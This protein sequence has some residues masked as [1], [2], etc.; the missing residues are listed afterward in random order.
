LWPGFGDNIR[1]LDWITRRVDGERGGSRTT[2]IGDVPTFGGVDLSGLDIGR[3]SFD[4]LVAVDPA[5]WLEESERN[6]GFLEKLGTRLPR[7]VWQEHQALIADLR[8]SRN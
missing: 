3:E 2:P 7:K 4:A 5:A 8:A 1:V 6:T